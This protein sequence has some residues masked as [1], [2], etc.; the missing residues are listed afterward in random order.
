[1]I[2]MSEAQVFTLKYPPLQMTSEERECSP[3]A[4]SGYAPTVCRRCRS[5]SS[6]RDLA[7]LGLHERSNFPSD[8]VLAVGG[9]PS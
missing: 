1:M 7:G 3:H 8:I 5:S 9:G 6:V 2:D 4:N